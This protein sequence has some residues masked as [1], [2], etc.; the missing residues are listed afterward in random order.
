MGKLVGGILGVNSKKATS[1]MTN[2]NPVSF[3]TPGLSADVT[4]DNVSLSPSD[5]RTDLFT[6]LGNV[7]Q[8]QVS[9]LGAIRDQTS[10]AFGALA[11]AGREA[12][13]TKSRQAIGN[14]RENL[15]RRRVMGSSFAS[16]ALA[17]TEREFAQGEAQFLAETKARELQMQTDLI[18]QQAQAA[19]QE[20][21]TQLNQMNI[22]AQLAASL[23]ES[24]NTTLASLAQAE[25]GIRADAQTSGASAAGDLIGLGAGLLSMG[26]LFSSTEYKTDKEPVSGILEK[27][28][29]IPVESWRYKWG[30]EKH[31]GPYAEDFNAAFG[32]DG[33]DKISVIDAIGVLMKSVQELASKVEAL[34]NG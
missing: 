7:F 26:S 1:P 6:N 28:R 12:F 32:T 14:L 13:A 31:I 15:T 33:G 29:D 21:T 5:A 3:S 24:M 8:T 23:T 11:Q 2:W 19:A 16:D 9:D 22:D 18:N 10:G 30:T 20:F 4:R 25:A 17:R 27:L 34:E